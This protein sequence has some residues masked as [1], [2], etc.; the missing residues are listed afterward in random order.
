MAFCVNC[1]KQLENGIK[2]CSVCG[3]AVGGQAAA[4]APAPASPASVAQNTK[5]IIA[6]SF[7]C[8]GCGESLKIPQNPREVVRCPSCI[9][10]CVMDGIIKNA[11]IAAKEN[12]NSGISLTATS[13]K[14][15]GLLVKILSDSPD[16]PLDVFD[17]LNVVR[18]ER[19]C[20]PAYLFYCNGT[21][22]FTYQAGNIRERKIAIDLGNRTRVEK[23]RYTEWTQMIGSSY[24][25]ATLF[26]SGNKEF[27]SQINNVYFAQDPCQLVDIEQLEFPHDVVTCDCNFPQI[28]S[29]NKDASAFMKNLLMKSAEDSLKDMTYKNLTMGDSNVQKNEIVRVFLGLYRI[30]YRYGDDEYS[31]WTNGSGSRYYYC[32][33]IPYDQIRAK[34]RL[35]K[36]RTLASIKKLNTN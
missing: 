12:I 1:G 20:V 6:K 24:T 31:L 22:S 7:R 8:S 21:A 11:E 30:V 13:D 27:S 35:Q 3:T 33:G 9:T 26:L 29:F 5:S 15:N 2:F 17:K 10:E 32:E 23:Q 4:S 34:D 25:T 28:A 16:I 14:L 19:Y 18:E 36:Q